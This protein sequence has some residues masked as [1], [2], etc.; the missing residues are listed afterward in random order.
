MRT[1]AALY[2]LP[3]ELIQNLLFVCP[4]V[5]L[6][7]EETARLLVVKDRGKLRGAIEVAE[8]PP[9]AAAH[10]PQLQTLRQ[11][12]PAQG[13]SLREEILPVFRLDG[14]QASRFDGG[15]RGRTVFNQGGVE[16]HVLNSNVRFS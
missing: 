14:K 1:C 6:G 12:A 5:A 8:R 2:E 7:G 13:G 10:D 9:A 3:A 4:A 16:G 11:K 15:Q